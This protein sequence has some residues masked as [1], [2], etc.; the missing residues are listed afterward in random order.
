MLMMT[1]TLASCQKTNY[2]QLDENTLYNV[3]VDDELVF[4]KVGSYLDY[5]WTDEYFCLK[6][7]YGNYYNCYFSD[8]ISVEPIKS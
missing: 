6:Y 2:K 1:L 5:K 4:T 3:Y 8:D 7:Y